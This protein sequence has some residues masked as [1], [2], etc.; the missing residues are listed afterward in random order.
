MRASFYHLFPYLVHRTEFYLT[1]EMSKVWW[2][3]FF[4]DLNCEVPFIKFDEKVFFVKLM[5][6]NYISCKIKD[7]RSTR[8]AEKIDTTKKSA[9]ILDMGWYFKIIQLPFKP[10]LNTQCVNFRIFVSFR[11]YV[12]STLENLEVQKRAF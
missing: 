2:R 8:C 9:I 10:T 1:V 6:Y 12:K 5:F 11:F 7:K 3:Y 4:R